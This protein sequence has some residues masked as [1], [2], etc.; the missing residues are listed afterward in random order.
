MDVARE[1]GLLFYKNK[2]QDDIKK[3]LGKNGMFKI[4]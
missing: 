3:I 1:K 2:V 4:K